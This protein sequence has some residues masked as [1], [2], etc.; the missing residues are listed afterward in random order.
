MLVED[1]VVPIV[2]FICL[3]VVL[4]TILLRTLLQWKKMR[5][6]SDEDENLLDDMN[7]TTQ[8][9]EK[10]LHTIERILDAENPNWRKDK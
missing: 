9:L 3:F 4:P 5:S 8:R 1:V 2:L 7:E 10:R 6:L